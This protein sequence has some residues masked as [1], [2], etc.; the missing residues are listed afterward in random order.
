MTKASASIPKTVADRLRGGLKQF[1]PIAKSAQDRDV[2]ESDTVTIIVD[3]LAFVLG[4]DKFK[5]ITKEHSIRGTYCDLAISVDDKL[6]MLI[7]AK[8][9]GLDLKAGHKRQV[10]DY[11]SKQGTEWV[12]LTNA[13]DWQVYHVNFTKPITDELVL[14]FNL[15]ELDLKKPDDLECLYLLSRE[16]LHK[17]ALDAYH[18]QKQVLSRFNLAAIILSEQSL[19]TIRKQLKI[20]APEIRTDVEEIEKILRKEVLKREVVEGE[21][22]EETRKK[23]EK[24][25]AKSEKQRAK[26]KAAEKPEPGDYSEPV[27][28]ERTGLPPSQETAGPY[29]T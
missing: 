3:I 16:G 1:Q 13:I 15:L 11:A 14:E 6:E 2:N 17:S 20:M 27:G 29:S 22:A 9:I 10:V 4:Y 12:V 19:K 7:E 8:A 26:K 28:G 23:V 18:T 25:L 21:K 24:M 5:E